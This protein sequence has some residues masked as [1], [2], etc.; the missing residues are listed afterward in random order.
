[1]VTVDRSGHNL[2][3]PYVDGLGVNREMIRLGAAWVYHE[4]NTDKSLLVE[5]RA[6]TQG[7]WALPEA[8]QV[9]HGSG[10]KKIG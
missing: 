7:L 6:A 10:G 2:A 5:A 9:S 1:M 8:A 4:Y 3:M